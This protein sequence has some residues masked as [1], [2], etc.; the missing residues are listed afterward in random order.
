MCF[1]IFFIFI[2]GEDI[3]NIVDERLDGYCS[4]GGCFGTREVLDVLLLKELLVVDEKAV[5]FG[6][7]LFLCHLIFIIVS[8]N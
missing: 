4:E 8:R 5:E 6:E 7:V 2:E 3:V 1:L